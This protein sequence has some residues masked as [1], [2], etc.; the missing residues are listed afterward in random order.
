[1]AIHTLVSSLFSSLNNRV[2]SIRDKRLRVTRW[3][4]LFSSREWYRVAMKTNCYTLF[5][6]GRKSIDSG[7]SF[8]YVFSTR[9]YDREREREKESGEI[10]EINCDRLLPFPFI[11]A[12][13][14]CSSLFYFFLLFF[15]SIVSFFPFF[16][17]FFSS[18]TALW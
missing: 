12:S 8:I 17:F 2:S 4:H 7:V 18:K 16:R 10:F 3:M 1:M 9:R 5:L 11:P 15:L 6:T 14:F 13:F